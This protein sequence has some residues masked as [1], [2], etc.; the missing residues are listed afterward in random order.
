MYESLFAIVKDAKIENNLAKDLLLNLIWDAQVE[1]ELLESHCAILENPNATIL[2]ST[3]DFIFCKTPWGH[4]GEQIVYGFAYRDEQ[5]IWRRHNQ[6]TNTLEEAMALY[7]QIK[8]FGANT[9]TF[10]DL[11]R[12]LS[13]DEKNDRIR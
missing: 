8:T 2:F 11:L 10:A 3:D 5:N 6:F 12:P 13:R 7:L 1:K 4:K 9:I